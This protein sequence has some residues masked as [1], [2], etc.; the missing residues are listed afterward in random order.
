M[1]DFTYLFTP[2][3]VGHRTV[4]NRICC[5]AHA[6]ALARDG[7]PGEV[8]RRYY[9]EKARGGVGLTSFAKRN[10]PSS[11]PASPACSG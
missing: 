11:T 9:E 6:D 7:M 5:S 1:P 2:I 4:K 3:T 10:G 8:A